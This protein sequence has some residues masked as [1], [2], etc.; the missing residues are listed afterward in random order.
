MIVTYARVN[1]VL[2]EENRG[3]EITTY[4]ADT[5]GSVIKTIDEAGA[6]Y[7]NT[8]Y[9]PY[10]EVRTS[11]GSNPSPWSFVGTLGYYKDSLARTYVRARSFLGELGRWKSVDPLWPSQDAYAYVKGQPLTYVDP[12][13]LQ[14]QS[15]ICL[16]GTCLGY[17]GGPCAWA[18]ANGMH[19]GKYGAVICCNGMKKICTF[20]LPPGLDATG[21]KC[22]E[23]HERMH[24]DDASCLKDGPLTVPPDQVTKLECAAHE[25]SVNCLHRALWTKCAKLSGS[26]RINCIKPFGEVLCASCGY[27]KDNCGSMPPICSTLCQFK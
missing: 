24:L 3:G 17:P 16:A 13:G 10:G 27:L 1:G 22:I 4:V 11:T 20:N 12:T 19:T 6:V 18:K 2:V 14:S 8:G 7:S 23:D 5:L 25:Y 15:V 21:I 9:W 26:A